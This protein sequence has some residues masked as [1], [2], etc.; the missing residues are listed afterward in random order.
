MDKIGITRN[1]GQL[2][3]AKI[4]NLRCTFIQAEDR[5]IYNFIIKG[6]KALMDLR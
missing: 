3:K 4:L 6:T 2:I 5:I 1:T